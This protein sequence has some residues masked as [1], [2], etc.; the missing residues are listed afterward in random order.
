MM[1]CVVCSFF[2]E[3]FLFSNSKTDRFHI[4]IGL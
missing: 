4:P 1:I 2:V 3:I